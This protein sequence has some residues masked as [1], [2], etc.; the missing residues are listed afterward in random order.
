MFG[1]DKEIEHRY[2]LKGVP[3]DLLERSYSVF[4]TKSIYLLTGT[5]QERFVRRTYKKHPTKGKGEK[6]FKR[7]VKI[8]HGHERLEFHD[9]ISEALYEEM[10]ASAHVRQL[11]KVRHRV[12]QELTDVIPDSKQCKILAKQGMPFFVWEIDIFKDRDLFL[13]ELEVPYIGCPIKAPKFL[14][15][16]I[17]REVTDE[18]AYEGCSLAK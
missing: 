8:G 16:Y 12:Q 10:R 15:K 1:S 6:K 5:I 11:I 4:K 17:V 2:L 7:T 14:S 18:I 3:E 13:A 9:E